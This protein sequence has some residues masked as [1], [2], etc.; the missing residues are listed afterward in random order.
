M[1]GRPEWF[2]QRRYGGWGIVPKTWQGWIYIVVIVLPIIAVTKLTGDRNLQNNLSA[3]W[4]GCVL[5]DVIDIMVRIKRD[6][7]ERQHEAL[8]ERNAAWAMVF[9]LGGAVVVQ[10]LVSASNQSVQ[11]D[12]WILIVLV[13]GAITKAATNLYLRDK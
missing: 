10:T 3:I 7:R 2:G 5:L 12:P 11:V 1:I 8:A 6:E 4:M 9:L 13:G